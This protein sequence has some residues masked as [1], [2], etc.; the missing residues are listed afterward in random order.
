MKL[1]TKDLELVKS[2]SL[3]KMGEPLKDLYNEKLIASLCHALQS[4][5]CEFDSSQFT[6]DIFNCE[7]DEKE[8]KARMAHI[9]VNLQRF[10]PQDFIES[11][12]IL[13][14]VASNF[15]GF[16]Y[17][18]FPGFVELYGLD[19]YE[20]SIEALAHFTE[21]SSSEFAVRPFIKKYPQRMMAQ[22][23]VWAK[24][25][26]HH[27]RRLASEGCRPRLPWA[28]SLPEFKNNPDAVLRVLEI[29]KKDESEYV[30][31]SVANNL[32]DISKDNPKTVIDLSRQWLGVNNNTDKIIK[33]ACRT[34]LKQGN[35]QVLSMFGYQEP[36]HLQISNFKVQKQVSIG[37]N[38]KFSV[39]LQTSRKSLGKLRIEYVLGF[40]KN[41]GKISGKVF[42]ISE[43][44]F[45]DKEK[46]ITKKHPFKVISTRKYYPGD[47]YVAIII[48]GKELARKA[49]MLIC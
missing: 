11:V 12:N 21:F 43:S 45:G 48:N 30:R 38:L 42:M 1:S 33:H 36:S 24:S 25:K 20:E 46:N 8:L 40:M 22:M 34:L 44:D 3:K 39:K 9:S 37:E 27:I 17:M 35:V 18:F 32:N 49:F 5:Y 41:N 7:W 29:L 13:K 31:K 47:H 16:Q 6:T 10:L 19:H 26:N 15:V 2:A 14:S 4:V 28:M 23:E